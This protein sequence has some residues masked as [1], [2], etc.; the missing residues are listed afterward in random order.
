[1]AKIKDGKLF[2]PVIGSFLKEKRERIGYTQET[3]ELETKIKRY[4]IAKYEKGEVDIPTSKIPELCQL[5]QCKMADCGKRVDDEMSFADV[6]K[7]ATTSRMTAV[8]LMAFMSDTP[9]VPVDEDVLS[10]KEFSELI[11]ATTAFLGWGMGELDLSEDSFKTLKENFAFFMI[12]F[13]KLN[14]KNKSR[15]ERL[16]TYCNE[17]LRLYRQD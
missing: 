10:E 3:V 13:I 14:E 9:M 8:Q 17:M 5:Y 15:R 7:T 2:L 1:M 16:V 6:A 4:N 11:K 12:E